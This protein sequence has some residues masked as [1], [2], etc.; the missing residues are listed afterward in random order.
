[1]DPRDGAVVESATET[2][3]AAAATAEAAAAATEP[4]VAVVDPV[5]AERARVAAEIAE[6]AAA[7]VVAI[8]QQQV[9]TA[10]LEAAATIREQDEWQSAT[11]MRLQSLER[12]NS[13]L[14]AQVTALTRQPLETAPVVVVTEPEVPAA[15]VSPENVADAGGRPAAET[16]P[17][18]YALI[19]GRNRER[20]T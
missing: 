14:R 11:E 18:R 1:M 20:Q 16:K 15:V 8:A 12:E 5:D 6:T 13:E 10:E 17:K 9:V 3:I 4:T 7:G 2:A 19:F